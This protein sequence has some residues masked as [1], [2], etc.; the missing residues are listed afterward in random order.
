MWN[1]K[2]N[3]GYNS[4]EWNVNTA[5]EDQVLHSFYLNALS[6]SNVKVLAV[7]DVPPS[8]CYN[9]F[10]FKTVGQTKKAAI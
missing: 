6:V 4:A 5:V 8:D 10:E 3:V 1:I 2:S 9:V 7:Q